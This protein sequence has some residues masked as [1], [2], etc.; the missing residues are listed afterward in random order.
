MFEWGRRHL[1]NRTPLR[2]SHAGCGAEATVEIRCAEG[3]RVR[4]DELA[5]RLAER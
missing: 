3:H 2:L 4:P 5:V 1:P